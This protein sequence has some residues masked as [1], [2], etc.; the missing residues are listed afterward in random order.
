[1]RINFKKISALVTSGILV[2]MTLGVGAAAT[3]PAPFVVNGEANAAV[4]YG[5]GVG[6]SPVDSVGATSIQTNLQSKVIDNGDEV[7][8]GEAFALFTSS[9]KVYVNDSLN[10][11]KS[12]ITDSDLDTTLADGSFDGDVSA[13]YTQTITLGSTPRMQ[14]GK[15]PTSDDDPNLALGLS[16][17]ATTGYTYNTTVTFNKVVNLTNPESEGETIKLFGQDYTI[18]SATSSTDLVLFKS[19]Q[20]VSLSVGG[21]DPSSSVITVDGKTYTI[22][23]TGATATT[24]LV[25][26][27]D[28]TGASETKE[29]TEDSSKRINGLDIAVSL[30]ASSEA[31]SSESATI[32]IGANRLEFTDGS[33]VKLGTDE[34]GIDNTNVDVV[35]G[36]HWNNVTSFLIQVAAQDSD[37]DAIKSGESYTDPVFGSFKI[38]KRRGDEMERGGEEG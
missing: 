23:L 28:S 3:Y 4:V 37:E 16:T 11:V 10:K 18:G 33:E 2:G 13:T 7:I 8:T 9:S 25:K 14:F 22:Q 34:E 35:G 15:Y 20:K 6:V 32:L 5:T 17:T 12:I 30:A 19:A 1:M 38:E 21:A 31:T 36:T 27:T 26:V 24:A 29:V